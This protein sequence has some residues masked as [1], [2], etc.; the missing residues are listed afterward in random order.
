M[1]RSEPRL[2]PATKDLVWFRGVDTINF[3]NDLISQEIATL[4]PG[5]VTRSLLLGPRGKLDHI[6]WVLRGD[7]EVGLIT[8][9]GRGAEL[10]ATLSR[11]RI[12]V[13]VDI[14]EP[15]SGWLVLGD[16]DMDASRWH[17]VDG[18]VIADLP[19]H[20]PR[21]TLATGE[22][23]DLPQ[24]SEEEMN[25]IRVEAAEPQFGVDVDDSTIPQESGLVS[26]TVDF[27]K[28][29]YLG[30]E[31]VARID[32]RG[33]VNR[34][35]RRLEIEG[36]EAEVGAE[37]V[38]GDRPVGTLTSVAGDLGLALLRREVEPGSRVKVGGAEARVRS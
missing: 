22:K 9:A 35:L 7:D 29:C 1:Q 17:H 25:R 20:G 11:Y 15:L 28:G 34:H 24:V 27:D 6:L 4:A 36:P 19:W 31:L 21:M 8:D 10:A 13:K 16:F 38:S 5:S 33:H 26:D 14:E 32:S 12:R 37:I 18:R 2:A 3:L 30:Q 23:P